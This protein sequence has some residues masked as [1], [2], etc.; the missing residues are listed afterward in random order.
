MRTYLHPDPDKERESKKR[1]AKKNREA[2][3]EIWHTIRKH[4]PAY[5]ASYRQYYETNRET[6]IQRVMAAYHADPAPV[7]ERVAEWREK[8]PEKCKEYGHNNKAKRK[9]AEGRH[10]AA[11]V[12][13]I[14]SLQKGN[15]LIVG[16][17]CMA[18]TM[19]IILNRLRVAARITD[20]IFRLLVSGATLRNLLA[21]PS[22]LLNEWEC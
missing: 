16:R 11:D 20:R 1:S 14:Y 8:N 21:I 5:Q 22:L 2:T 15:A 17:S 12:A 13:I 7:I 19:S 18:I 6:I 10:T 4:D 9:N 3:R